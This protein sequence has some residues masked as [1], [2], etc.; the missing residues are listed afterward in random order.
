MNVIDFLF[1]VK[2]GHTI[3]AVETN[4][5]FFCLG[6]CN[7]QWLWTILFCVIYD[8][9]LFYQQSIGKSSTERQRTKT[10]NGQHD[11][12]NTHINTQT[13]QWLITSQLKTTR[14]Q[15]IRFWHA[16][17]CTYMWDCT[18]YSVCVEC[19]ENYVHLGAHTR[20]EFR[21]WDDERIN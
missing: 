12:S 20:F 6:Y 3:A 2:P 4:L 9:I 1:R 17:D 14:A 21:N 10:F 18:Q 13:H 5:L 8:R 7:G 11:T 16:I 15:H 19:T